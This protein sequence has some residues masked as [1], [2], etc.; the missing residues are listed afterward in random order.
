MQKNNL[1]KKS[2]EIIDRNSGKKPSLFKRL[3]DWWSNLDRN[4]KRLICTLG[5]AALATGYAMNHDAMEHGYETDLDIFGKVKYSSKK[6]RDDY[7]E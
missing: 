7:D 5:L 4:D 6:Y 2:N 3:K 1:E